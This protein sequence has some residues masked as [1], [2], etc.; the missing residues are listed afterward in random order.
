MVLFLVALVTGVATV[1]VV[2]SRPTQPLPIIYNNGTHDFHPTVIFISLDGVVNH[3]LDLSITPHLSRLAKEGQRAHWMTP[4]FPP[5]TFPNHWSLVTGLSVEAHG[6]IGNYFFDP[7]RNKSFNYKSP[8]DSWDAD[9]WGGEPIWITAERQ[10]K[11]AGVIMWP[12]CSSVFYGVQPSL[13]VAY[14][15]NVSFDD[16]VDIALGWLDLPLEDRP[17]FVGLYVPEIDQKGHAYGP[18]ASQTLKQLQMADGTIGRLL[19]EIDARNLTNIVH[20]MVVSDHGMS[21]TDKSRLIYLDD[22]LTQE[23]LDLIWRTENFPALAIRPYPHADEEQAV[24]TL[25]RAFKRFQGQLDEPHF[26]VYKRKDIPDRFRFRNNDRI[27]PLFVLPDP[28]WNFVKRSEFDPEH[29]DFHPRGTHGYDNLSPE[30][31]AI[32][33]ARGPT[34]EPGVLKPFTNTELY[35]VMSRVLQL[36]PAPNHGLLNGKLELDSY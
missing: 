32:F 31:R 3:D 35:Q 6:I 9:W 17:Q 4:S 13:S 2:Q 15:D 23:E 21:A 5:I 33:V 19:K 30:S 27:A 25:Y 24:D 20:I 16:K 14:S 11:T 34:F 28:G 10:Q 1:A 7:A 29:D 22:G 12:G 36:E 8:A 18:Y 26:E